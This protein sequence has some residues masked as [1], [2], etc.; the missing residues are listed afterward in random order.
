MR[1]RGIGYSQNI[2][3]RV[4]LQ[5][6]NHAGYQRNFFFL[7]YFVCVN[8]EKLRAPQPEVQGEPL[9][10][11]S[12]AAWRYPFKLQAESP[13]HGSL[14]ISTLPPQ[15]TTPMRRRPGM[16]FTSS[17]SSAATPTAAEGSMAS[18]MRV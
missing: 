6:I 3:L 11:E 7:R 5:R 4:H 8:P 17:L 15:S 10:P 16:A 9:R 12:T 14:S 1:R 2:S 13:V 18:F